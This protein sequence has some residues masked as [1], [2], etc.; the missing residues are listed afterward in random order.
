M[1]EPTGLLCRGIRCL[2][3]KE[4]VV[5]LNRHDQRSCGCGS[6]AIDGGQDD[7]PIWIRGKPEQYERVQVRLSTG[8]TL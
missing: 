7:V 1:P 5:S 3:C 8:W 4:I 2:A 6:V